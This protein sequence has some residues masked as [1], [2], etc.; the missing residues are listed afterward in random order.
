MPFYRPFVVGDSTGDAGRLRG[1]GYVL[2]N[3]EYI[4][5]CALM[6]PTT[7]IILPH[8]SG[9][10]ESYQSRSRPGLERTRLL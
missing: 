8:N 4:E 2:F 10:A 9:A 6:A 1:L 3:P 7:C 5:E